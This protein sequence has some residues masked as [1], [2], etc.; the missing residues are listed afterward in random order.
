MKK[1]LSIITWNVNSINARLENCIK[2][3]K[4]YKP[5]IALL[6]ELK[7]E[8]EKFPYMEIEDLGYNVA[9]HGQKTYN[10]V[11][12]LSK[13]PLDDIVK[14]IPDFEDE[15]ARYIEA[16]ASLEDS[17]IRV[18]SVYV[19][20]GQSVGSEKFAYKMNFFDAL[21]RHMK[22]IKDYDE[23]V[24][25]GGDLN[26]APEDIDVYDPDSLR[27]S[28]CFHPDEQKRFRTIVNSGYFD[29]FRC[30]NPDKHEFS[31]WDYR[32][33]AWNYN[34]GMRIDFLLA[35]SIAADSSEGCKIISEPRGEKKASD[36]TP[37]WGEIS[38]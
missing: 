15:S 27:G 22:V 19:P 12:I 13:Y 7:C 32:G 25:V 2:F 33:G 28:V 26:V 20:N 6:Q 11:A 10:G 30:H 35:N 31:W 14:G 38:I 36:H 24:I 8:T 29:L 3:L 23:K 16:I 17:A 5:D 9:A 1:N 37:V 4:E 21:T 18:A 34:K